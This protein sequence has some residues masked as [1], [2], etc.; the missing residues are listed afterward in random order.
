MIILRTGAERTIRSDENGA[1][2]VKRGFVG[3]RGVRRWAES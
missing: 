2:E 3:K 1:E